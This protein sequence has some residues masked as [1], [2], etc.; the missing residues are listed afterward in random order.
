[1][2]AWFAVYAFSPGPPAAEGSAVVIIARGTPLREMSKVLAEAGLVE[3]DVRFAIL[4]RLLGYSGRIKA[5][6]FKLTTGMNPL[7]VLRRL[8]AAR[9][10]QHSVTIPEGLRLHEIGRIFAQGGWCDEEQFR[11][12]AQNKAFVTKLGFGDLDSLEGYL[13]PDTYYLTR[14]IHGAEELIIMMTRR[15]REVWTE[16]APAP[17]ATA[18]QHEVVILASIVEK[19]TGRGEERPVIAGV[20]HNRLKIGMRLQSDPTVIYGI[21]DFSG[22]IT[23]KH[24]Q[25]P[26]RYNTYTLT[27][28]PAGPISNPGRSAL[29]AVLRP[30]ATD[31][32]YFVGRNDG[33]HQF[34]RTL[35]EHNQAV[36]KYQRK[37]L[38]KNGKG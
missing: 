1:M 2:V 33:T 14:D 35:E 6:E 22:N 19:E 31:Y 20:F 24:L 27:G 11:R 38:E 28:L 8:V 18:R 21:E 16:V 32:L 36:R 26:S 13:F 34:S 15:F 9:P 25:T 29:E 4:A 23:R 7:Q 10:I 17:A 5:G 12:L 37:K 3:E 30:A